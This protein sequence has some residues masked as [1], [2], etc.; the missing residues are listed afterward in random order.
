MKRAF[1][2]YYR[3]E[4]G[5]VGEIAFTDEFMK[6]STLMQADVIGD[7]IQDLTK[8]YN[9]YIQRG[10]VRGERRLRSCQANTE[11]TLPTLRKS[12]RQPATLP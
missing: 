4:F 7:L 9:G 8:R 2:V 10:I 1:T 11:N 5:E 3:E 12:R 6:E